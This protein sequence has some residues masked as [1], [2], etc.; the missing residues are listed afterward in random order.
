MRCATLAGV[1]SLSLLANLPI[2]QSKASPRLSVVVSSSINHGELF[3][4]F[5]EIIKRR[6]QPGAD[7]QSPNQWTRLNPKSYSVSQMANLNS[8]N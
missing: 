8:L 6:L 4:Y 5:L 7:D 3:A 1:D 2:K